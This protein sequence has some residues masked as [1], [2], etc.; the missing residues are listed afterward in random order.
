[1]FLRTTSLKAETLVISFYASSFATKSGNIIEM[2]T[3]EFA[4]KVCATL[5]T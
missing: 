2:K 3:L 1:M 4:A 5:E